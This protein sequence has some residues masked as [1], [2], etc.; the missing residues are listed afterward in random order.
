MEA[1]L[2]DLLRESVR[3][4]VEATQCNAMRCVYT[5]MR[6]FTDMENTIFNLSEQSRMTLITEMNV[7]EMLV[8]K[9]D[10][11]PDI[12]PVVIVFQINRVIE[13]SMQYRK[14]FDVLSDINMPLS[15]NLRYMPDAIS[16]LLAMENMGHRAVDY[17]SAYAMLEVLCLARNVI[18]I[19]T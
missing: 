9:C 3:G 6:K 13:A 1:I 17:K 7:V 18:C 8:V 19:K 11:N 16:L 10:G 4:S 15:F 5:G 14:T 2:L 12:L